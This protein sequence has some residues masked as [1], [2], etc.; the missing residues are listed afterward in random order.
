MKPKNA[1]SDPVLPICAQVWRPRTD[2]GELKA[3]EETLY[4]LG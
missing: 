3:L 4:K 2:L 1:K